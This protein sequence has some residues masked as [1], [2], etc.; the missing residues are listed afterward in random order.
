MGYVRGVPF[1]S[2]DIAG[3]TTPQDEWDIMNDT[4]GNAD[5]EGVGA[6]LK[7]R[8]SFDLMD[9]VSITAWKKNELDSF[10]DNDY[11]GIYF[12]NAEVDFFDETWTQELQFVSNDKDATFTWIAGLF[13]LDQE[14]W[15]RYTIIGPTFQC[16]PPAAAA[17]GTPCS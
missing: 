16:V 17:R 10:T 12:N 13:F 6:S 14:A 5:F 15:G 8:K 11:A 9:I 2:I 7:L 1:G 3:Q 4:E